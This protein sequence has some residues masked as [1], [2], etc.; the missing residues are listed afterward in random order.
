MSVKQPEQIIEALLYFQEITFFK[1]QQYLIFLEVISATNR[2]NH[3]L[4]NL[5]YGLLYFVFLLLFYH[6]EISIHFRKRY[7]RSTTMV[8]WNKKNNKLKHN[9]IYLSAK[10]TFNISGINLG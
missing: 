7:N 9:I 5:H 6:Y 8:Q 10:N 1:I 2:L 4:M 3:L